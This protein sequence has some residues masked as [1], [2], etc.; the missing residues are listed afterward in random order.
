M[1][2]VPQ[3]PPVC[4]RDPGLRTADDRRGRAATTHGDRVG[5]DLQPTPVIR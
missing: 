4:V 3:W 1:D 5:P 2:G